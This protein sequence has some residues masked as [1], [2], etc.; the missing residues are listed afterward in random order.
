[1]AER[2]FLVFC[3]DYPL[4]PESDVYGIFRDSYAGIR[5]AYDLI[6][7]YGGDKEQISLCGD[8]AGGF[9]AAYLSAA[10]NN[11]KL[12]ASLGITLIDLKIKAL[13]AISGMF[14]SSRIDKQ[15]IFVPR[16]YF[17]GK[18]YKAHPFW[19]YVNEPL[20]CTGMSTL[21]IQMGQF[22]CIPEHLIGYKKEG[23]GS[24]GKCVFCKTRSDDM[25][26]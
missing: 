20:I 18:K 12:A 5:K 19:Q 16:K 23:N 6:E 21:A 11:P 26:C 10:Q 22:R 14:Y 3:I 25:E 24:Y 7:T 9:I 17:Y 2:G 1:M 13:A 15:G 4:V 8:S